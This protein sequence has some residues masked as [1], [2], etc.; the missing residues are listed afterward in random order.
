[1]AETKQVEF[2]G[3]PSCKFRSV[4]QYS[5]ARI[6]CRKDPV[7]LL[8]D[9]KHG[10]ICSSYELGEPIITEGDKAYL[11]GIRER[12]ALNKTRSPAEK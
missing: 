4:V 3:C 10:H 12:D 2:P 5:A 1:M 9:D 6:K 8:I 7:H 11:T